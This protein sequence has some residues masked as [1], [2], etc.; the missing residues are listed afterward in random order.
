M[1]ES[2]VKY[3]NK[4]GRPKLDAIQKKRYKLPPVRLCTAEYYTVVARA[5]QSGLSMT[6]YARQCIVNGYVVERISPEHIELYHKLAGI[7]NNMN[8]LAHQANTFGYLADAAVYGLNAQN[9]SQII[10]GI[11]ND[12]K[13]NEREESRRSCELHPEG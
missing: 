8:Q 13:N 7:A 12:S 5:K 4:G 9:V 3:K 10:K 2:F 11:F 1:Q 6:E